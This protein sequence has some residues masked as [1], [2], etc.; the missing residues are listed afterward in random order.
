MRRQL[1]TAA[2]VIALAATATACNSDGVDAKPEDSASAAQSPAAQD[3]KGSGPAQDKPAQDKPAQDQGGSLALGGT[4]TLKAK[5]GAQ[6]A[7]TLKNFADP[8]ASDNKYMQPKPGKR[9]VAAQFEIVNKGQTVYDDSPAN[10]VK[11]VDDQ[12]QAFTQSIGST[13][14]GPSMPATVKL[15]AGEKVLGYVVVS[16]PEKAKSKSVTFTPDS[17]FGKETGQWTVAK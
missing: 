2:V 6:I 8:A 7:V 17:G 10:G 5:N 4:A 9:W 3:P 11:V 14:A 1:S 12:G 13:T 16:V 15:K